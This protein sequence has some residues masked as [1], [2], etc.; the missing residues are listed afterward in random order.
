MR[1][2]VHPR[3][4]A[5]RAHDLD[6]PPAGVLHARVSSHRDDAAFNGE[7]QAALIVRGQ[8]VVSADRTVDGAVDLVVGAILRQRLRLSCQ[9]QRLALED[10]VGNGDAHVTSDAA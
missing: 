9:R 1:G 3:H 2:V 4:A 7:V 5:D 6:S 8:A 10:D